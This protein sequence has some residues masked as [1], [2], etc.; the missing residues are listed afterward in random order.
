MT[1]T[2][3]PKLLVIV[4][5]TFI[6]SSLSRASA[7]QSQLE[8]FD[9]TRRDKVLEQTFVQFDALFNLFRKYAS[10]NLKIPK[11]KPF[12]VQANDSNSDTELNLSDS[13]N[14]ISGVRGVFIFFL[15]LI[16]LV[17]TVLVDIVRGL[18]GVFIS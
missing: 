1:K 11:V 8:A 17:L 18:L 6:C 10:E 7:Q 4:F 13:N 5:I 14:L 12:S 15:K 3:V 2:N 16:L 9:V